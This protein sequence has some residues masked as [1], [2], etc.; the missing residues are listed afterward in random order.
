MVVPTYCPEVNLLI[1][2]GIQSS[3]KQQNNT[4]S[5]GAST[6]STSFITKLDMMRR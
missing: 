4:T 1:L 3:T 6:T 5:S 2:N